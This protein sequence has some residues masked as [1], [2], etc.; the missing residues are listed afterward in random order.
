MKREKTKRKIKVAEVIGFAVEAITSCCTVRVPRRKI[1]DTLGIFR[2]SRMRNYMGI[3]TNSQ[4]KPGRTCRRCCNADNSPFPTYKTLGSMT[5][6]WAA[7]ARASS[8]NQQYGEMR[9]CDWLKLG[10]ASM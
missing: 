5:R 1:G 3:R 7:A 4:C 2:N 10:Q 9:S 8:C 6:G